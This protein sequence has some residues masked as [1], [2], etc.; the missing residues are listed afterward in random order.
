MLVGYAARPSIGLSIAMREHNGYS[1]RPKA[2]SR[3]GARNANAK[4][5]KRVI[6]CRFTDL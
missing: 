3:R 5:L 1:Q 6:R 2:R 4:V